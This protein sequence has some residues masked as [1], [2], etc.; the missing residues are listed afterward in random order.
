VLFI[1]A[2]KFPFVG[3]IRHNLFVG[4]RNLEFVGSLVEGCCVA[5]QF[6][7]SPFKFL[8]WWLCHLVPCSCHYVTTAHAFGYHDYSNGFRCCS[9]PRP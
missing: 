7:L 1:V 3:N 6:R 5:P 4:P 8:V 9:E 2:L